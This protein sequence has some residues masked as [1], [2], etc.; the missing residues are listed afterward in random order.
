[1]TSPAEDGAPVF[2]LVDDHVHS[3]RLFARTLRHTDAPVQV[4][5][6]GDAG[7]ALRS[8][9]RSLAG[10][11]GTTPDMIVVDLKADSAAN[12]NFVTRIAPHA[13]TAGVPVAVMAAGLDPQKRQRLLAAGAAAAFDRHHDLAAYR[14]EIEQISSFWVR[15]TGTWP[16]RA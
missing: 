13:R 14:R 7:R 2:A 6:L 10:A 9:E 3:A 12:E 16:I 4:R 8:L 11:N 15:E 5:W 1:M